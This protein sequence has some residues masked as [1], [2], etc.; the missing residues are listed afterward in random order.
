MKN[1]EEIVPIIVAAIIAGVLFFG[2]IKTIKKFMEIPP[3][4]QVINSTATLKKQKQRM[5][6]I[7][8][9]QKQLM[10]DQK[11]KIRDLNRR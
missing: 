10:R 2:F 4:R 3:E 7:Q 5:R 11:Q 6:D 8:E 1:F 9:R